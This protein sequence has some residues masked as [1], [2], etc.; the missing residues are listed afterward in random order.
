MV[1]AMIE[2]AVD[3]WKRAS[4]QIPC[5]LQELAKVAA[6]HM[7]LRMA[8]QHPTTLSNKV[9]SSSLLRDLVA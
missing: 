6:Q 8:S 7:L 3:V 1:L 9:D 4:V 2:A 5:M